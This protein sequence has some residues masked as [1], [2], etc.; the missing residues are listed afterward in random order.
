M[1]RRRRVGARSAIAAVSAPFGRDVRAGLDQ[2]ERIV[3]RARGR[4][5]GLVVLPEA[6]LGGY[7]FEPVL[8]GAR[9]SVAPPPELDRDGPEIE[10][11]ARIAG[12]TVV[13]AGY[14]EVADGGRYSS[15]VCVT[16]DGVLGHQRKVHL[17][18]GEK[19]EFLSG[20]RFNAFDTP[21]GRMGMLVCYDKVFPE[22]ARELSVDGADIVASLAAWPVCR[23][24]PAARTKHDRQVEHFNLL[25]R[26]RALENQVIWVSANQCGRLGRLRFPGQAKVVDP[27][28]TVL[29]STGTRAGTALAHVDVG[30]SLGAVRR[31]LSHLGDRVPAAY[32]TAAAAV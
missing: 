18:P 30:D 25:D 28:G 9:T 10:R 11:L 24:R 29:A 13:C 5:A 1:M 26:A 2:I 3:S 27:D 31:E 23:A 4:G 20:E 32:R 17:P 21:I 16:G 12:D 19:G 22:A 7:L 6:A 8:P 14:T 15:A